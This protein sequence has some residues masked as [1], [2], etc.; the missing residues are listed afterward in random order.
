VRRTLPLVIAGLLIAGCGSSSSH[1]TSTS[2]SAAALS[3]QPTP[4]N[5][6]Q[7]DGRTLPALIKGLPQ[8]P[9]LGPTTSI[10]EPGTDRVGFVLVDRARR[11]IN[12]ATVA[13]YT[14]NA[15]GG[16]AAGPFAV[17]SESL[18]V[19]KQFQS[20]EDAQDPAAPKAIYVAHIPMGQ[21]GRRAIL[22]IVRLDGKMVATAPLAVDIA[23]EQG[24]PPDI[25]QKAIKVDTPTVASVG[26]DAS[27]VDTR[28]PPA[29]DLEQ[30]NLAKVLG[31]KPVAL[32]FATPQFCQSRTCGPVED[33]VEQAKHDPANSRFAFVHME[34]YNNNNPA[35]GFR[36]QLAAWRLPS[37]PWLFVIDRHGVIRARFEGAFAAS[38]VQSALNSVH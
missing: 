29:A 36:P 23:P 11:F 18:A 12:G 34:V 15:N 27:K 33:I 26:G 38:E 17:R 4:A 31:H 14:G 20:K 30:V 3:S 35:K 7:L 13:L 37:E 2:P 1:S 19:N 10:F 21:S 8:G 24:G 25:G 28:I 6:P 5:F 22:G 16:D 9:S 32:L